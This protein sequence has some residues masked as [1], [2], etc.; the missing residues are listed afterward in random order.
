M[1][2]PAQYRYLTE[3]GTLLY[4]GKTPGE[5]H[6][7]LSDKPYKIGA[8]LEADWSGR[9]LWEVRH[10]DHHHDGI[11]LQN[12]NV[13]LLTLMKLPRELAS[14]IKGGMPG[15][16][17][18]GDMYGDHLVEMSTDG[19]L[20]REYRLWEQLDPETDRI[21]AIQEPR[22][23]WSNGNG[24]AEL[25][26]GDIVVSFR[27]SPSPLSIV[28]P[29][30]SSGSLVRRLYAGNMLPCRSPTAT[31]WFSTTDRTGSTIQYPSRG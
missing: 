23:V 10:R 26:N 6:S 8:V 2:Y 20:L 4:N 5:P 18:N 11:L 21:T 29:A 28:R 15:S 19:R 3:R 22:D 27:T 1:P 16:E 31:Y 14:K 30:P 13:M 9:V 25:P 24:L 7:F 12:G 17:H